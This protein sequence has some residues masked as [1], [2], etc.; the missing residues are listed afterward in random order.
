MKWEW[1][2][3][4]DNMDKF[5]KMHD[6]IQDLPELDKHWT[7]D[8]V[9][10]SYHY[11]DDE[12]ATMLDSWRAPDWMQTPSSAIRYINPNYKFKGRLAQTSVQCECGAIIGKSK[13]FQRDSE[14]SDHSDDCRIEW[15]ADT[16]A[17]MWR[18][19]RHTM[20]TGCEHLRKEEHMVTRMGLN[21]STM[22]HTAQVLDINRMDVRQEAREV[23]K[24]VVEELEPNYTRKELAK[25]FDVARSTVSKWLNGPYA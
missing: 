5:L 16:E 17:E 24:D 25:P 4:N 12:V 8:D 22:S 6:A 13:Q 19:R 9:D 20:M 1:L 2:T 23:V 14:L 18:R 3:K 10:V 11:I 15:Q 21:K 7:Y